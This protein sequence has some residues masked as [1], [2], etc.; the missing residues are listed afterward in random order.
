MRCIAS[1]AAAC[2]AAFRK[3]IDMAE[4]HYAEMQEVIDAI[5][6]R[7]VAGVRLDSPAEPAIT[8]PVSNG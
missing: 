6:A 2:I 8:R 7:P 1:L 3:L 4:R 5:K